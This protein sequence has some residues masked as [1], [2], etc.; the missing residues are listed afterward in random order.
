[1]EPE[2]V[3]LKPAELFLKSEPV[4]RRMMKVLAHNVKVALK[5]NDVVYDHITKERLRISVNSPEPEEVV[6]TVKSVFGIATITPAVVVGA[7]VKT[8]KD[9]ALELARDTGLTAR[10]SFAI[11]VKRVDKSV[12]FTSKQLEEDIGSFVQDAV[13]AKVNLSKPDVQVSIELYKG[14]AYISTSSVQGLAGLPVGVSGKVVCL[15][16][17]EPKDAVAAWMMLR[18]GCEALPLHFRTD[19]KTQ[20]KFIN[21]CK[22]LEKFARGSRISPQAIKGKMDLKTAEKFA[23]ENEAKALVFG[24]T[25]LPKKINVLVS[26]FPIFTPLVGLDARRIKEIEKLIGL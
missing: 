25:K 19:E 2:L 11:R 13:K 23:K 9:V 4:M 24:H 22:K 1:M 26:K 5:E 21:N 6:D 8:I 20:Q 15:M 14:K 7:D 16:S 17:E 3:I 10:K 12:K 18:R